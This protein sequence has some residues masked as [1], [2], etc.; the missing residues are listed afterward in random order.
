MNE[1][2]AVELCEALMLILNGSE[3]ND[4]KKTCFFKKWDQIMAW[5]QE[6]V[7][8]CILKKQLFQ[9]NNGRKMQSNLKTKEIDHKNKCIFVLE[10]FACR[11]CLKEQGGER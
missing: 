3:S 2:V 9:L 1:S 11:D 6:N 7:I 4:V 5:S 8:R 10:A